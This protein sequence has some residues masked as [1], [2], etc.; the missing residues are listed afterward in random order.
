M[1]YVS[2][3][4]LTNMINTTGNSQMFVPHVYQTLRS[5]EDFLF[6]ELSQFYTFYV[7]FKI[8]NL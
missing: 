2:L 8:Q 5:K 1:L 7:T 6:S 4:K 3:S